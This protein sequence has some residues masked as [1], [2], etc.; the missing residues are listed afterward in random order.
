[1]Y[2]DAQL[3][4][5]ILDSTTDASTDRGDVL[6]AI[7][8]KKKGV[9]G[10]RVLAADGNKISRILDRVTSFGTV[11]RA[12]IV[13]S[14]SA[15]DFGKIHISAEEVTSEVRYE[16]ELK[17][18]LR[19][20]KATDETALKRVAHAFRDASLR[21]KGEG[22]AT[23]VANSPTAILRREVE[24][25]LRSN[26]RTDKQLSQHGDPGWLA[27]QARLI[28]GWISSDFGLDAR[29][30]L[31]VQA[32]NEVL[33]LDALTIKSQAMDSNANINLT[34]RLAA[35]LD[36]RDLFGA[37]ALTLEDLSDRVS[38]LANRYLRGSVSLQQYR[39]GTQWRGELEQK[40]AS[41]LKDFERTLIEFQLT[42]PINGYTLGPHIVRAGK[43]TFQPAGWNNN[44]GRDDKIWF[45]CDAN[46]V[47]E[48]AARYERLYEMDKLFDGLEISHT[49]KIMERWLQRELQEAVRETL[50]PIHRDDHG[51]A[52]LLSSWTGDNGFKAQIEHNLTERGKVAGLKLS[53][54]VATPS[55]DEMR[56][57]DRTIISIPSTAFQSS[58][59][60]VK[61]EFSAEVEIKVASFDDIRGILNRT[62]KPLDEIRDK[63][64]LKPLE[65]FIRQIGYIEFFKNF[66]YGPWPA[67][68]DKPKDGPEPEDGCVGWLK[69]KLSESLS[70]STETQGER[71][72][73]LDL[74]I[75]QSSTVHF[76]VFQRLTQTIPKRVKV[77]LDM[78]SP[79]GETLTDPY[80][81]MFDLSITGLSQDNTTLFFRDWEAIAGNQSEYE[82]M[83]ADCA[84]TL[85]GYFDA[86]QRERF[87]FAHKAGVQGKL[88][89]EEIVRS[90]LTRYLDEKYGLSGNA[91]SISIQ[92]TGLIGDM[93]A[94]GKARAQLEAKRREIGYRAEEA[95]LEEQGRAIGNIAKIQADRAIE[96]AAAE[97][98]SGETS[99]PTT[100]LTNSG[101]IRRKPVLPPP[102][103]DEIEDP[104]SDKKG[105]E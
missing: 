101:P 100:L 31:K 60:N 81:I 76:E 37:R 88:K 91:V 78:V 21:K 73:L 25:W 42:P 43:A 86:T 80:E 58:A 96:D 55:R 77:M 7:G 22:V 63:H 14:D 103:E 27:S 11:S 38:T 90:C 56:L 92:N 34:L 65:R 2:A 48:D 6:L 15:I 102:D 95:K 94:E 24:N 32:P 33:T 98:D 3:H 84:E 5:M 69:H 8:S 105:D 66:E 41:D 52:K 62:N 71:I 61:L 45:S 16:L 70:G 47:V 35:K 36:T 54:L 50:H 19:T 10:V 68:A 39:F 87:F 49:E 20:P 99:T 67:K 57:L 4:D 26:Y 1:M 104:G 51:Y 40:I 75:H 30:K 12:V 18:D 97:A 82:A 9:D 85:A 29:A 46:I 93:I 89:S 44:E 83:M 17:L 53:N 23:N 13:Q 72:E 59:D 79:D 64:I 28:E 74:T